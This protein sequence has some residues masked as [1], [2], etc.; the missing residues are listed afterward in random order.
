M[1]SY[2]DWEKYTFGCDNS[3]PVNLSSTDYVPS[4]PVR[5]LYVGGGPGGNPGDVKVD[6]A[7]GEIGVTFKAVPIGKFLD[8]HVTKVY[9]TGTTATLIVAL[10]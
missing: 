6:T 7:G 4:H 3:E 10:W 2:K 8:V 9:Q 1:E 5:R